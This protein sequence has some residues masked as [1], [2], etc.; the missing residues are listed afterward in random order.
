MFEPYGVHNP[1]MFLSSLGGKDGRRSNIVTVKLDADSEES[2]MLSMSGDYLRTQKSFVKELKATQNGEDGW[3][4]WSTMDGDIQVLFEGGLITLG[5]ADEI[6]KFT[7]RR[8]NQSPDSVN[9]L[10]KSDAAIATIGRDTTTGL[11]L[12]DTLAREGHGD[13]KVVS[14]YFTE[15]RFTK[16]GMKE[17]RTV[18]DFGLIGSII[19]AAWGRSINS[20]GLAS[21]ALTR[22][23]GRP[24]LQ[25]RF[26]RR[27]VDQD[28]Q[29]V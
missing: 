18:S 15:T 14:K 25:R 17:R 23:R 16:N 22:E 9:Q 5:A 2:I 24:R 21:K 4:W 10:A 11:N 6:K 8:G 20:S 3:S 13:T 28:F 19:A 7:S 1:E 26:L 27:D 29:V 12:I